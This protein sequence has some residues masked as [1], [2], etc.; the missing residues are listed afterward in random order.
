[1]RFVSYNIQY[2]KGK[3]GCYDL[4]RIAD[5]VRSADVIALQEVVRNIEALPDK[6]QPAR[7]GEL[8][9]QH[10]WV[11]APNV[12]LDASSK[13]PDG[14]VEHRRLQFGNMV[15]SRWPILSCRNL[16]L[17]RVR[18][19]NDHNAQRGALEAI[20]D[21]PSGPLRCYSVHLD[22]VNSRL[23]RTEIEYLLP[24]MFG[25]PFTGAS[26]TGTEWMGIG[27]SP[28]PTEFVVMGDFNLIPASTE[29]PLI[30]GEVDYHSGHT[31]AGD[32]LV[33]TWTAA[34]NSLDEGITWY[35]ES[36]GF[37]VGL[38][39]DYGFVTPGLASMVESAWIDVDA[40]GSD[41]QPT[42]FKLN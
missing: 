24:L 23:R 20:I 19:I 5:A 21:A 13:T 3:D 37:E 26:V 16:L 18:V 7:L 36:R 2:S 27:E 40:V 41:H 6:D 39:L 35:D 1:M 33:D 8:L 22:S 30:V 12:D 15:L 4:E 42:W 9:A 17:P 14:S 28:A 32:R 10:H 25:V 38:R 11:Y 34:G 31:L 29:Y